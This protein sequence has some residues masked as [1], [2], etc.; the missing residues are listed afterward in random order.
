MTDFFSY[1]KETLLK[2]ARF[3]LT[4][5]ETEQMVF[6]SIADD[7]I[8]TI[9]ENNKK[10]ETTVCI[11]PVGPVGQYPFFV[12]A[13]NKEQVSLKNTYFINMDEYLDDEDE[14]LP[15]NHRLSFRGFMTRE[16]YQ[17]IDP[18]L[19]MD[20]SHRIFPDPK[21]P[22]AVDTLITELGKIDVCYGGIG[23]NGH[24]AFNEPE[25]VSIE[26]FASRSTRVLAIS[27][28]T[29]TINSVGD[30]NGAIQ[31]MPKRCVTIGMNQILSSRRIVL[32]CFRTWHRA[33]IRQALCQ[34][35]NAMFPSTLLQNHG[36]ASLLVP[37]TVAEPAYTKMIL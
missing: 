32:G 27:K 15:T 31:A 1:D 35:P 26:D 33:V 13:V 16:V 7:M 4:I 34:D 22:Q 19:V 5:L 21:H 6:K 25:D 36:N 29:R 20:E 2:H 18:A 23:I 30:L 9:E 14:Y 10:Q 12:E 3:P 28:E 37:A 17:K 24:L 8:R 11:V